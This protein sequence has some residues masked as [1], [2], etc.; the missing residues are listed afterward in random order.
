[1]RAKK[2][3]GQNFLHDEAVIHSIVRI[4]HPQP[5]QTMIEIG[6]GHGAITQYLYTQ[7]GKLHL[8]ELDQDLLPELQHKFG[9]HSNTEI[10]HLDALKLQLDKPVDQ[11]VGNLPYNISTPLLIHF[12]YQAHN[13]PRMVFMLQKEV[14]DRICA[15]PNNKTYGRLSV[16]LQHRYHCEA[17]LTIPPDAFDPAPK[18]DSQIISLERKADSVDVDLQKLEKLVKQAFSQRRKTI[19]NNLKQM[20]S[21]SI[22][23]ENGIDPRSRPENLSVTDYQKLSHHVD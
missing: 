6:P 3:L 20:I 10:H 16:M 8:I 11:I 22:L 19:K 21:E 17:R 2:Q 12:L 1:M 5:E 15:Q 13:I 7:V 9:N 18:V 23:V 14:V 4:I